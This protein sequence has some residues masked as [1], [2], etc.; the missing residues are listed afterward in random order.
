MHAPIDARRI[1]E[2]IDV[3]E[4]P[5]GKRVEQ[6]DGDVGVLVQHVERLVQGV[7]VEIVEQNSHPH[8]AIG[9]L[10]HVIEKHLPGQI[11][12]PEKVLNIQ[13]TLGHVR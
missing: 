11:L 12:M 3:M 13:G 10:Q 7:V 9:C 8:T 1:G 5:G 4:A 2:E 6:T